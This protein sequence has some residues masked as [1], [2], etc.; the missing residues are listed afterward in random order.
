MTANPQRKDSLGGHSA[1]PISF[2]PIPN[3]EPSV[4]ALGQR[5]RLLSGP[6]KITASGSSCDHVAV[7]TSLQND[8]KDPDGG[9]RGMFVGDFCGR[10]SIQPRGAAGRGSG[11]LGGWSMRRRLLSQ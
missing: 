1:D 11:V 3:A 8:G 5:I 2:R 7:V 10:W 6:Q 9:P 4:D